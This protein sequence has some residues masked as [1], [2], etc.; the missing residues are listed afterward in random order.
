MTWAK[1]IGN[2]LE[3]YNQIKYDWCVKR[4]K[5][6]TSFVSMDLGYEI[7]MDRTLTGSLLH[8]THLQST[9]DNPQVLDQANL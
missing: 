8:L 9:L 3:F 4:D 5:N 2:I 7:F 1:H 6:L